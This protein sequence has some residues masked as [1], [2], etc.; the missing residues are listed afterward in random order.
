[1]RICVA[2]L[3][4]ALIVG[5]RPSLGLAFDIDDMEKIE[6][7]EQEDLLAKAGQAARDWKFDEARSLLKQ[8]QQK[9][10]APTE[11]E[12]VEKLIAQN[13]SAKAEQDR[14]AEEERQAQIAAQEAEEERQRVASAKVTYQC[15]CIVDLGEGGANFE[16]YSVEAGS[17]E[18][19]KSN[20][21]CSGDLAC[22]VGSKCAEE[23]VNEI[24]GED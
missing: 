21:S 7:A 5:G 22:C 17:E 14:R 6:K 3:F 19:A 11:V 15:V 12:A 13:E 16:Y 8:A 24:Y 23:E 10:Y 4:L 20:I 1:M 9:G 18:E 2:L